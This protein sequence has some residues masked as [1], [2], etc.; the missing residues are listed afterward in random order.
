MSKKR[1][2]G[3]P[4]PLWIRDQEVLEVVGTWIESMRYRVAAEAWLQ[5]EM[6]GEKGA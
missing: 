3:L 2:A 4:V 6:K 5:R 1:I